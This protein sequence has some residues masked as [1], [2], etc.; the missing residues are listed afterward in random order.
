MQL[1]KVAGCSDVCFWIELMPES[2]NEG[3]QQRCTLV[4]EDISRLRSQ[5]LWR[6]AKI[7][8]F[9]KWKVSKWQTPGRKKKN[10][11]LAMNALSLKM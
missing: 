10:L 9:L 3:R 4:V 7:R 8:A 5:K 11:I 1:A 2:I 6:P